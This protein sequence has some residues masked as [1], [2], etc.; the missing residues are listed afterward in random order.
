MTAQEDRR[1]CQAAIFLPARR[2]G[3]AAGM[4][5]LILTGLSWRCSSASRSCQASSRGCSWRTPSLNLL[6]LL[7]QESAFWL[8]ATL[9][10]KPHSH[11][12][13]GICIP[14]R[15]HPR[16][17][18]LH[19]RPHRPPTRHPQDG[20]FVAILSDQ[21]STSLG[22]RT[23]Q[24]KP[25]ASPILV[26]SWSDTFGP[27]YSRHGPLPC[28]YSPGCVE[29][30]F[31][32]LRPDGVFGSR[33]GRG[34]RSGQVKPSTLIDP[35]A[36]GPNRPFTITLIGRTIDSSSERKGPSVCCSQA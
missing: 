8:D 17:E 27:G 33:Q 13:A 15:A 36:D 1:I 16:G 26:Q 18:V 28:P 25:P 14:Q 3:Y 10:A 21:M 23:W 6:R 32:E 19:G 22:P 35:Y 29:V 24:G 30:R 4:R 2:A 11:Q 7:V 34:M 5:R 12:S 9:G 20:L 31:S